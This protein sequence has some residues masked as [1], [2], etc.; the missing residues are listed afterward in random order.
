MPVKA[1]PMPPPPPPFTWTGFYIGGN[2][3]AAWA[4]THWADSLFGIDWGRT[5]NTRFI[6][7]GQLGFNYEFAGSSF[8]LGA[9][10]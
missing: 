6:G 10:A 1:P 7:G 5:S 8:V 3:G 9:E 4:Q 2:I